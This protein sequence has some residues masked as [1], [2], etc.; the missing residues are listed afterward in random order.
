MLGK[1]SN[2]ML[3]KAEQAIQAKL[4]PKLQE[5]FQR[6][7]HAGLTI[8]YSPQLAQQRQQRIAS[9]TNPAQDAAQGAARLVSNLFQ[10]S[11]KTLPLP[12]I[13]PAVMMFAFEYLDLVC[14][15]GKAQITP[16][17]ISSTTTAVGD[18]VMPLFRITPD[19]LHQIMQERGKNGVHPA[20]GGAAPAPAAGILGSAQA[21]A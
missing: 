5:P 21:G 10:Q 13:V 14:K 9:G 15:A 1:A 17:L 18:A 8:M 19:K 16:D 3:E 4:A 11:G 12:L 2:P 6:V 7:I 20:A